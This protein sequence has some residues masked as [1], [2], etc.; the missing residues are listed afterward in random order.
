MKLI[1][2]SNHYAIQLELNERNKKIEETRKAL[3]LAM[4]ENLE[5][6][7]S[8]SVNGPCKINLNIGGMQFRMNQKELKQKYN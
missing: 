8:I 6:Y 7:P 4:G 1:Q 2:V 3:I 5:L